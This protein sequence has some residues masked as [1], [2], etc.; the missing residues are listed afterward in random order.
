M[1]IPLPEGYE[2]ATGKVEASRQ[3]LECGETYRVASDTKDTACP[4]CG[5]HNTQPTTKRSGE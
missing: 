1:S 5:S 4:E 3:C 2:R